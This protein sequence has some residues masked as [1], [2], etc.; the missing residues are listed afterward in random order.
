[1]QSVEIHSMGMPHLHFVRVVVVLVVVVAVVVVVVL[2]VVV[3]VVVGGGG[4]GGGGGGRERFWA[5]VYLVCIYTC[6]K[7]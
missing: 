3:L 2:V 7:C 5:H 1:M 4:G 6:T